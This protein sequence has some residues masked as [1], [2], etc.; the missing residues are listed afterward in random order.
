MTAPVPPRAPNGNGGRTARMVV[1][2]LL[3]LF[4]VLV[5]AGGGAL[6]AHAY[7]N[8][9]QPLAN[10][11]YG[12]AVWSDESPDRVFPATIGNRD[13]RIG[14]LTNP[15]YAMWHRL[16]ISPDTTC[17]KG[18]DGQTL[19]SA[20]ELGCKA[21]LRAT[22][23]DPS[24]NMVATVAI[25]VLPGAETKKQQ[26]AQAFEDL[27]GN[28][29][30][31]VPFSVPGTLAAHWKDGRNGAALE[32]PTAEHLPYAVAATTGSVDGR[33]AATLPGEWGDDDDE[34]HADRTSYFAEAELLTRMFKNHL[35]DLQLSGADD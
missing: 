35:E 10:P 26:L 30:A 28:A 7:S 33:I 14:D 16:G 4:G 12:E 5:L 17:D 20:Q 13:S 23:V 2:S 27:G 25:V 1:G 21:V 24:G 9:Q 19:K 32:A 22:Y 29:G 18:L 3:G 15:K 11:E 34:I 8:S 31:V 6:A